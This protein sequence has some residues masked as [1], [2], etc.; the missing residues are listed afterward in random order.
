MCARALKA[1]GE[2]VLSRAFCWKSVNACP[3]GGAVAET[4]DG[5]ITVGYNAGYRD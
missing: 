1:A 5:I 3:P 2:K 4:E